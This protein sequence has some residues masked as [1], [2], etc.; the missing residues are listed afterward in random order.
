MNKFILGSILAAI[1]LLA[2]YGTSASNRVTSWV[3]GE[4]RTPAQPLANN[5]DGTA[6][7]AVNSDEA[8]PE[9]IIDIS[10]RTPL[11][12]AGDIP[13]RQTTGIQ[14][15]P[16]FGETQ[17]ADGTDDT[18]G[19]VVTPNPAPAP[20]PE[21]AAEAPATPQPAQTAPEPP[22]RALW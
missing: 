7:V 10:G 20:A 11:Q 15:A 1:S 16:N 19:G 2:I 18:G 17:P 4:R 3:D 8:T 6:I 9:P 21:P 5:D 14:S 13:Q 12:R 22:V